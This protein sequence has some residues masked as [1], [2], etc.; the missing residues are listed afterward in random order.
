MKHPLLDQEAIVSH[1]VLYLDSVGSVFAEFGARTQDSG[2]VSYGVEVDGERYFIKTAGDPAD[3]RPRLT[4]PER[5]SL[6]RN[7]ARLA[8][9]CSHPALPRLFRVIE[10]P[11]GPMLVYEWVDGELL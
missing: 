10:S 7:A 1:P 3:R 5:V 8:R 4:H 11:I 9:S 6:L 2:N